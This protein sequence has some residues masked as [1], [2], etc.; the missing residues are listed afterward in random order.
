MKRNLKPLQQTDFHVAIIGGGIYG[1]A[2]ARE[3]ATRG[4]RTALIEQADFCS[5]TSANS[6]KI[7]H[8]GLRYL[9]QAD[10]P[11]VLESIRERR[12]LL[13]SAPHLVAPMPCIMPTRGWAMKSRL[14]MSIG[15]LANDI[16]S[17]HRN[18][19]VLS[20][21]RIPMGKTISR[22]KCLGILP[23]L[24]D[25]PV[26]GAAIW[27]DALALDSERL[28]IG[29]L[30]A[31]DMAGAHVANYV[32]ADTF[33][34]EEN[35]VTGIHATDVL[36]GNSF[37]VNS[38]MVINAA[39]PWEHG[40]LQHLGHPV[41]TKAKHLALA[42][43]LVI[44]NWPVTTHAAGLQ[45]RDSRRL[46]FF[47][48]WRGVTLAGTYYRAIDGDADNLQ[49]TD[50]DISAYLDAINA[51][52]PGTRITRDDILAVHAG[53]LPCRQPPLPD[54]EPA[55]L[56]HYQFIDHAKADGIEGLASVLGIKYTTA[57]GVAESVIR[58]L[59]PRFKTR[60]IPSSTRRLPLPGGDIVAPLT[61]NHALPANTLGLH[62][63][64]AAFY[65]SEAEDILKLARSEKL[66][67]DDPADLCRAEL[68]FVIR[69]E[70]PQTL[71]DLLFRRTGRATAGLPADREIELCARTM[72]KECRWDAKRMAAEIH[73]VKTASTLWQAACFKRDP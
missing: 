31:A 63:R 56:R 28:V 61:V 39:G 72:A 24:Q 17:V 71:G 12:Q 23:G 62:E 5:G 6:L 42:M 35:R 50:N 33:R 29:M 64:L 21:R 69:T 22:Q 10:L 30:K 19:G 1:A 41:T 15:M 37:T 13:R 3:A 65:G 73:S 59:A 47:V 14:V 48:P 36:T 27:H 4:L 26:T 7:I 9:Q 32:K 68:M 18:D 43:N 8:G 34:M 40:L 58:T 55:L 51:C 70:M 53:I 54:R 49:V 52:L 60:M 38:R 67:P 44:R 25:D 66:D 20:S 16:L 45:A 46:Y 57:R 2:L 11:R